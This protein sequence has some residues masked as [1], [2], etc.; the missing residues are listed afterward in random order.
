MI[1]VIDYKAGNAP[2]VANALRRV[3]ASFRMV[4]SP[5]ELEE[6]TGLIL[7]GVGSAQATMDSLEELDLIGAIKRHVVSDRPYLGICIGFQ[8][9]F[10][11]S[12][13]GHVPCLDLL[14]G[15]V[16]KFD[17]ESVRVPQ[18]G[19]NRVAFVREDPI[20]ANL[21]AAD[22]FYFVN[23]YYVEPDAPDLA[24]GRTEYGHRFCS[25]ASRG[26]VYGTQFHLEKSAEAG[27]Q[28]LRNFISI[29]E[30]DN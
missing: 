24:L 5:G 13:E 23:S 30:G 28:V 29:S 10:E 9:L 26:K 2:S 12:Q 3:G 19:W 20:W 14:P 8:I 1:G 17:P 7:P 21:P 25:M 4:S 18:I 27:L 15:H 22:Y 11:R 16:K 6:M